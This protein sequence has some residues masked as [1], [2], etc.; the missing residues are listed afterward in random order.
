MKKLFATLIMMLYVLLPLSAQALTAG[1]EYY[2]VFNIYDKLLG[3]NEADDGPALSAFGTNAD[4]LSYVFVAEDAGSGYF[5]LRQKSSG[6]YLAASTA[7]TWSMTFQSTR[8]TA[9]AFCWLVQ[10]NGTD[11]YLQSKKNTSA[12]V[13]V[14]GAKK[15]STYVSVYYD[16]RKGSHASFRVVPALGGGFEASQQAYR[17][18]EFTNAQGNRQIDYIQLNGQTIDRGDAIDIHL[19]DNTS[20]ILAGSVNL[21]SERTWLVFDNVVPSRV[22]S[23]F[24]KY[25]TIR[26][27]RAVSGTNCRVAI[28][29]NGAVVI[30]LPEAPL[31]AFDGQGCSGSAFVLTVA[32]HTDLGA[33]SNRMRSFRLRRGYMATL[34]SGTKGSGYSRVYVA[35]HADLEVDLPQALDL[36]VTSAFVRPWQYLSKKGWGNT[37]GTSGGPGLRATWYWSWSAAYNSTADMEYVPCR[38]HRYWPS[39]SDVNAHTA[40]AAFSINEPEHSEQHTSDKCS[41]GGTIDAWTCTTL[42]PEFLAGG[43]RIGSPQPTDFSYLNSYFGHVDDMAYRC[44]FAVTH[45]YWDLGDRSAS[46]YADWFVNQCKSIY[47]NTKRPVWLTEME[48]SASWN[49][50]KV[51]SYEQNRQYLQALLERIDECPWIERYAIYGTDMWQTYMYYEA[52]PS[53]GLTPA[54]EV[55]RDHRATFAYDA[56]YQR[57]SNWWAPSVKTPLLVASGTPESG[58]YTFSIVNNNTDLTRTLTVQRSTDGRTWTDVAEVTDRSLFESARLTLADVAVANAQ[59]SDLFRVA[60]TTTLGKSAESVAVTTG[61]LLANPNI[62]V[63]DKGTVPGWTCT[64]NAQNGFTKATGDTYLEVWHPSASNMTFDYYQD[65]TGLAEGVYELKAN[66][67]NSTNGETGASVGGEVG[68]YA[69]TT[70]QFYFAPVL[71]DSELDVARFT[72]VPQIIVTD[73]RL[74]VGIRNLGQMKARWAGADNFE[75]IY[76]GT[77]ADV[78]TETTEDDVLTQADYQLTHLMTEQPGGSFDATRFLINADA[79]NKDTFGWTASNVAFNNGEAF[80]AGGSNPYFDKWSGS[81]YS[82]RLEQTVP[83]LPPGTYMVSA[84]LRSADAHT[85]TLSATTSGGAKMQT[86]FSGSGTVP[87]SATYPKW[88]EVRVGPIDVRKNESLTIALATQG[89]SWWSADHFRLTC[90]APVATRICTAPTAVPTQPGAAIFDLSGRRTTATKPG[91]YITNGKKVLKR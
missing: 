80:D 90:V 61:G 53:K 73:G 42:T 23:A 50:K 52:N 44:D 89:S 29:L 84:L 56:A 45:A 79:S 78:L 70:D 2:I 22:Q 7:N 26:G 47:N 30:P 88:A 51:T 65:V 6:R 59:A 1:G 12:R 77:I 66:V 3:S 48:V 40:S 58:R 82:S 14:D 81:A 67:F 16:K 75:L 43:G 33:N 83:I 31:T 27:E 69:Q 71:T 20:P 15:G 74:R 34:A 35:D 38:Q 87:A 32:D 13:G 8:S 54:G 72:T 37:G 60:L 17:S 64:R 46:S 28:Y 91:I 85:L 4:P 55:Y 41:C 62:E 5:L 76:L 36:R 63:D 49:S 19:A 10:G 21:G 39:A 11:Q 57:V 24:L 18:A 9:D 25:V 86:T 68:L